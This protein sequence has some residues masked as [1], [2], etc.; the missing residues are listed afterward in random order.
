M[1]INEWFKL[2]QETISTYGIMSDNIYN[3][4]ETG[5]AI[6]ISITTR[7]ITR[8]SYYSRK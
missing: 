3:F 1:V 4:D 8:A 7:V 5:F 2:V 6:E